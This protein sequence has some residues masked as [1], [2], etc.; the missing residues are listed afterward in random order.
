MLGDT[1]CS[2]FFANDDRVVQVDYAQ[3]KSTL[4]NCLDFGGVDLTEA[5]SAVHTMDA[6]V[7]RLGSPDILMNVAGGFTLEMLADSTA[8]S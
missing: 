7:D 5:D 6:T 3:P 2:A 1:A 8:E 4:E